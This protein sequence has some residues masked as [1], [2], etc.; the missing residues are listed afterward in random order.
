MVAVV[1]E[2]EARDEDLHVVLQGDLDRI[3]EQVDR[4]ALLDHD[5]VGQFDLQFCLLAEEQFDAVVESTIEV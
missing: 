5:D 3:V 1:A 2:D 4:C